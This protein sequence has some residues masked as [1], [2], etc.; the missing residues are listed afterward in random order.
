MTTYYLGQTKNGAIVGRA[1]REAYGYTFA[2]AYSDAKP[3]KFQAA[4]FS[5]TREGAQKHLDECRKY[6]PDTPFE[7]VEI[8]EVD[9]KTYRA[10]MKTAKAK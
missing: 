7:L 9:G 2:A 3:G 8:K 5:R 10:V 4:N 6:R 1:S